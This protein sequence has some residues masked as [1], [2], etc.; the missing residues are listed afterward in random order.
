VDIPRLMEEYEKIITEI[1]ERLPETEVCI[2]TCPPVRDKYEYLKDATYDYNEQLRLLAARIE[3]PLLDLYPLLV[4]DDKRIKPE[5][6]GDGLHMT[7]T[8]KEIW[9][10]LMDEFI[11]ESI[12]TDK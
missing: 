10:G 8:A 6:T 1:R 11:K 5:Y 7:D 9:A 2:I 3:A 4:D 12:E